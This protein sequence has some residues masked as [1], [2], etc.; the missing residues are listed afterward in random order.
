MVLPLLAGLF[1]SFLAT[2][3]KVSP[4]YSQEDLEL[5]EGGEDTERPRELEFARWI[6]ERREPC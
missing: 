4:K 6:S 1:E 5:W 2:L 3:G